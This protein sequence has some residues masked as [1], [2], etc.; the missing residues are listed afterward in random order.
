M[1][2]VTHALLTR[3]PLSHPRLPFEQALRSVRNASFD[4]HVL[5]T[6]PA[7][8]LSQDQTLMLNFLTTIVVCPARNYLALLF[9]LGG[10]LWTSDSLE[11]SV[12]LNPVLKFCSLKSPDELFWVNSSH[13]NFQG[14]ITVYLSRYKSARFAGSSKS[15]SQVPFRRRCFSQRQLC[16][17]IT[18]FSVC[19]QLFK[20]FFD[21]FRSLLSWS[22]SA[23]QRNW[24]YHWFSWLSTP[25][26][27]FFC[28][29]WNN[30][31]KAWKKPIFWAF[32]LFFL[33]IQWTN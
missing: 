26:L 1:R 33:F 11:S 4:L 6:P 3:P 18:S 23:R 2:Q 14:C 20:T 22:I 8:I 25:N 13:W 29:F 17:L 9:C 5:S 32:S 10:F 19:Q 21:F 15:A 30:L 28:F 16:Y 31:C 12:L 7:F 24:V 27:H